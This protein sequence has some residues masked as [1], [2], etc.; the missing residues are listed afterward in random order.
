MVSVVCA[1]NGEKSAI[2]FI[3]ELTVLAMKGTTSYVKT[4]PQFLFTDPSDTSRA[5]CL[6]LDIVRPIVPTTRKTNH[7]Y[8]VNGGHVISQ[9]IVRRLQRW[10]PEAIFRMESTPPTVVSVPCTQ[11]IRELGWRPL[12]DANQLIDITVERIH[13]QNRAF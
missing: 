1:T 3:E 8:L 10:F 11:E 7:V 13:K 4:Q 9:T 6:L 2:E 5:V 12:I